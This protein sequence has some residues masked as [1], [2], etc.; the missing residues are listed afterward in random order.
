MYSAI[1]V[2]PYEST[3]YLCIHCVLP[4]PLGLGVRPKQTRKG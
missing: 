4:L 2:A 3:F 1:M